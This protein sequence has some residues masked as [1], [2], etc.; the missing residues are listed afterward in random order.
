MYRITYEAW[1]LH[2]VKRLAIYPR[3]DPHATSGQD[4]GVG[5]GWLSEG[6]LERFARIIIEGYLTKQARDSDMTIELVS[7]VPGVPII[8]FEHSYLP[9]DDK[10]LKLTIEYTSPRFFL[11]L[12]QA[13]S[14]RHALILCETEIP[15]PIVRVSDRELFLQVFS[16][17]DTSS[18]VPRS[19]TQRI[20][21]LVVPLSTIPIP[22]SQ[23]IDSDPRSFVL[24][25]M[26]LVLN[27]LE[28]WVYTVM[29]V[30]FVDGREPWRKWERVGRDEPV[31]ELVESFVGSVATG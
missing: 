14:P 25:S 15:E 2:Y 16:T 27:L 31:R 19:L 21:A 3:P 17:V 9:T 18:E 30:R 22:S 10:I 26:A 7:T 11:E 1:V 5:I 6:L 20:R 23:P 4:V 12:I 8:R 29:R 28:R 13:P 24:V